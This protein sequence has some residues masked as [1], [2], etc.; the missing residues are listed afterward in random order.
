LSAP[1]TPVQ[2]IKELR[3]RLQ[4]PQTKKPIK[5]RK[6]R[7]RK[8]KFGLRK[9]LISPTKNSRKVAKYNSVWQPM[10]PGHMEDFRLS[11]ENQSKKRRCFK[12]IQHTREH[13]ETIR[14][15]DC[16]KVQSDE[17]LENIGKVVRLFL[18]ETDN[19]INV[20]VLW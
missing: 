1:L 12:A 15:R 10:D 2:N 5:K 7:G 4:K 3:S 11:H 17:G 8:P 13:D 9:K 18:D 14:V 6:R 19:A 16:I 20:Q